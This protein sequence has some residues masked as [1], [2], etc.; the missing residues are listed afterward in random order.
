LALVALEQRFLHL[1]IVDLIQHFPLLLRRVVVE[2]DQET[3]AMYNPLLVGLEAVV[4]GILVLHRPV[5][6]ETPQQPPHLKETMAE[7]V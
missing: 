2:A 6:Q 4:L 7:Q 3:Q 1:E 5:R